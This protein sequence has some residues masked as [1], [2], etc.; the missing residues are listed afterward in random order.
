MNDNE[1][2]IARLLVAKGPDGQTQEYAL[3]VEGLVAVD[4]INVR[5]MEVAQ[6]M[7]FTLFTDAGTTG[8]TSEHLCMLVSGRLWTEP[9]QGY[10]EAR[11]FSQG[12]PASVKKP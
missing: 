9:A 11:R 1:L 5:R 2:T 6:H 4:K 12:Y 8:I 10:R 3:T 7:E